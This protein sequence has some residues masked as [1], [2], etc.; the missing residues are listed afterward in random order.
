MELAYSVR[1]SG[2]RAGLPGFG[3]AAAATSMLVSSDT[4]NAFIAA[5]SGFG[6]P[7]GGIKPARTLRITFSA[8]SAF[9]SGCARSS[10]VQEKFPDFSFSLWQAR[11]YGST[12]VC[13]AYKPDAADRATS[14]RF[15]VQSLSMLNLKVNRIMFLPPNRY[16]FC[17]RS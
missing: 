5:A 6:M 1:F 7:G 3:W 10:C 12:W 15:I 9:F 11:E 2:W 16:P 8:W 17:L 13:C 14:Q 4:A